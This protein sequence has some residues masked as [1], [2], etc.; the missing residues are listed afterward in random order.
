M[1]DVKDS[2][3]QEKALAHLSGGTVNSGSGNGW[4]RKG[5]VRTEKEL[6]ELK[7]TDKKS[8]ALKDADLE[9]NSNQALVDGRIPIFLVEFKTTGNEWIILSKDDYLEL[10]ERAEIGNE[11]P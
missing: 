10:R 7:I 11:T 5:D 1:A 3:R 9:K 2:Q 4:V 8:Y 6:W